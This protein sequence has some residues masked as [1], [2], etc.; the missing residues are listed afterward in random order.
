MGQGVKTTMV[1]KFPD[2]EVKAQLIAILLDSATLGKG[3]DDCD[4]RERCE[5]RLM[6]TQGSREADQVLV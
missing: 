5:G 1:V 3:E 2:V 4:H 6:W